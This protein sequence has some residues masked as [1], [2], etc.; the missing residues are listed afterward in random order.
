M[1][2]R[3]IVS[4]HKPSTTL[5][6]TKWT[7]GLALSLG[8]ILV[9]F[10][11]TGISPTSS[12]TEETPTAQKE[13]FEILQVKSRNEIVVWLAMDMTRAEFDALELPLRWFK[14]QPRQPE[15][16]KG[17]FAHSPGLTTEG[18]FRIEEH[19]GYTWRHVATVTETRIKQDK[20]GYLSGN[21]ITKHHQVSF[22]AG[23]TVKLL[24]SPAGETYVRITRDA[25]RTRDT[26]SLPADWQL[27]DKVLTEPWT[28]QLPNP[29]LNIRT[30]NEDS[31]QGPVPN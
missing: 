2:M 10:I 19:F 26:F 24:V 17:S 18:A 29:T 16:D 7:I 20:K 6:M 28:V 1:L 12:E 15:P 13:G 5:H 27:V 8:I 14:N 21:R 22:D 30:D 3:K 25:N 4:N 23:K 9:G 11:S 31:F